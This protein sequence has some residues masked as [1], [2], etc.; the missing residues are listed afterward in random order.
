MGN[1]LF[2]D[3]E[4]QL[5]EWMQSLN[6]PILETIA[7]IFT[8][9]GDEI[10][11]TALLGF[12]YWCYDKEKA[13][14]VV[15]AFMMSFG[16]CAL[17]KGAVLRRRPY[18]VH[19]GIDCLRLP[20]SDG[21]AMNPLIQGFSCPSMHSGMSAA[22][23]G[24]WGQI[25]NK[26]GWIITAV[27]LPFFIGLSRIFL[28]VHYPTDVGLGWVFGGLS[29]L[30]VYLFFRKVKSRCILYFLP[31]VILL[32]GLFYCRD[33]E[34]FTGLGLSFGFAFSFL[35]EEKYVNF[36]NTRDVIKC[37]CRLVAG[38]AV[39]FG[40]STLLKLPFDRAFVYS[41]T[42]GAYLLRVVRYALGVFLSIGVLPLSFNKC[43]FL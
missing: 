42:W 5:M 37:I 34:Y 7:K 23:M 40:T 39:F 18:M 24:A 17:I 29:V 33:N 41:A 15:V 36:E 12:L 16:G 31:A 10:V 38:F 43:R 2:F 27:V 21:D 11:I 30:A 25:I 28:G 32:P 6:N 20:H 4:V 1:T 35:F 26:R 14:Y 3:W 8:M 22:A 13:K 9:F 19:E